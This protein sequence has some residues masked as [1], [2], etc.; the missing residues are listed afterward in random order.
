M[1]KKKNYKKVENRKKSNNKCEKSR[2][3]IK[4]QK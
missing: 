3:E 4:F 1:V 2:E